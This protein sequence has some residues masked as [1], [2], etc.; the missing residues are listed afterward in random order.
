MNDF[1]KMSPLSEKV[2]VS[3]D[4]ERL[5]VGVTELLKQKQH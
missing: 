5:K 4:I 2:D 1:A 3:R